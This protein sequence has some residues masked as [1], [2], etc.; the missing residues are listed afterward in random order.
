M[1]CGNCNDGMVVVCIDD[2][3]RAIGECIHGDGMAVCPCQLEPAYED[4]DEDDNSPVPEDT[5]DR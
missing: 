2:I 3:C 1:S 4:E 5:G